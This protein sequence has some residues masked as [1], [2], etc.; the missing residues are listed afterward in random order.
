MKSMSRETRTALLRELN[1]QGV[2]AE[3]QAAGFAQYHQGSS[4]HHDVPYDPGQSRPWK[5]GWLETDE[6]QDNQSTLLSA[7]VRVS[8]SGALMAIV[9]IFLEGVTQNTDM[10][11]EWSKR[12]A[13]VSGPPGATQQ[14]LL[15]AAI[16]LALGA[17]STLELQK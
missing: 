12:L 3:E 8:I 15:L 13:A 10:E 2:V 7:L 16:D 1:V 14:H 5:L 4:D 9:E 11:N 6:E 17:A